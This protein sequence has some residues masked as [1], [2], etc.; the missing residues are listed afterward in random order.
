[1]RKDAIIAITIFFAVMLLIAAVSYIGYERWS[2][3]P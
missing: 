3:I 2:D 1:M